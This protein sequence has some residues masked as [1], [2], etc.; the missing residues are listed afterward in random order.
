MFLSVIITIVPSQA[1]GN[2]DQVEVP[3]PVY[4]QAHSLVMPQPTST[5]PDYSIGQLS[6]PP[7]TNIQTDSFSL[8]TAMNR[9]SNTQDN[10]NY[11]KTPH[12]YSA[13]SLP[14]VETISPHMRKNII[15]VNKDVDIH[16]RTHHLVEGNEICNN[17]NGDKGCFRGNCLRAH[18]CLNCHKAHSQINCYL[19]KDSSTPNHARSQPKNL[20]LLR[21]Q[22]QKN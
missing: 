16:G 11:V 18:I 19:N 7:L 20:K 10:R 2:F 22:P 12:G 8:A 17:F 1:Q 13:E 14:L 4:S 15:E 9:S 6:A 21:N 5:A 3:Q